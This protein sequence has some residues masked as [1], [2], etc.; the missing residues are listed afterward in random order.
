MDAV[1]KVNANP[2]AHYGGIGLSYLDRLDISKLSAEDLLSSCI[3]L[4]F[5]MSSS[6]PLRLRG[7]SVTHSVSEVMRPKPKLNDRETV[8]D[9]PPVLSDRTLPRLLREKLVS[10]CPNKRFNIANSTVRCCEV[11]CSRR[12]RCSSS[13]SSAASRDML[14]TVGDASA[15]SLFDCRVDR[16]SVI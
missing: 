5:P 8:A 6:L 1:V 12:W 14:F 4:A 3:D 16:L 15:G 10:A 11:F 2:F 13:C 9:S 7:L